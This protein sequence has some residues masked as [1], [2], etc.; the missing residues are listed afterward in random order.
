MT[1]ESA[2]SGESEKPGSNPSAN[3]S[4]RPSSNSAPNPDELPFVAPSKKLGMG[5]PLRWIQLGWNDIKH[6]PKQSL[7]YGVVV[8]LLS[9]AIT[10]FAWTV[11]S[12]YLMVAMLSGFI[13]I[14]PVM[15]IGLYSISKQI[16]HGYAPALGYCIRQEKR[17]LG[18]ELVF[19][20]ILLVVVLVWARAASMVHVFFPTDGSQEFADFAIFLGVGSAVGSIFATVVFCASAF[21]LPMIMDKNVDTVT[22]VLSSVNAVLRNKAVMLFWVAIIVFCLVLSFLTGLLGL[23]VLMPLIGH[24]TWHAYQETIDASQWPD[25]RKTSD[26]TK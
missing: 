19:A 7:S 8:L 25:Y 23:V 1:N 18:S 24:A 9:Y 20:I 3:S 12:I 22:A 4:S 14:G 26:E 15:A 10:Y 16:Q 21:S 13:F 17:H 2:K 6:A 11:G 5:A